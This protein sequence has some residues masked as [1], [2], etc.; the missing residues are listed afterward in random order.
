MNITAKTRNLVE[1]ILERD[2]KIIFPPEVVIQL[3][4]LR[5]EI[6]KEQYK[7]QNGPAENPKALAEH[8]QE[9]RQRKN[10]LQDNYLPVGSGFDFETLQATLD[11]NITIVEWYITS[12]G[13]ET[14][15][16]S[17]DRVQRF[18][19]PKSNDDLE[20]LTDLVHEYWNIY[21]I[22]KNEWI[23]TLAVRLN[24]FAQILKMEDILKLI[25]RNCS[26]LILIPHLW[27]HLFPL[28]A[29]PLNNGELLYERFPDG[30]SYAPSLQILQQIQRRKRPV[31][32][33][34]LPFKTQR[35]T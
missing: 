28:H 23:N 24:H 25:P 3:E 12:S 6:A 15:I 14:F 1:L 5:D 7:I 8:L 27:L 22:N 20:A 17:S 31:P 26:R 18:N 29:L 13:W 33:T 4:Q 11:K 10:N 2:S 30:V 9:L 32:K 35:G 21:D 16:I 34:Y 19:S